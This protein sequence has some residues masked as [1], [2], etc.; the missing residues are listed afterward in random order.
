[1]EQDYEPKPVYIDDRTLS[2]LLR[3]SDYRSKFIA[4][5]TNIILNT[6]SFTVKV[7]RSYMDNPQLKDVIMENIKEVIKKL[8]DR[9]KIDK[10]LS[11]QEIKKCLNELFTKNGTNYDVNYGILIRNIRRY[12]VIPEEEMLDVIIKNINNIILDSGENFSDSIKEIYSYFDIASDEQ[13]NQIDNALATN[14]DTIQKNI[15]WGFGFK[16]QWFERM[17]QF[18]EEISKIGPQFFI[19]FPINDSMESFSKISNELFE[20]YDIE[21]FSILKFGAYDKDKVKLMEEIIN[22]LFKASGKEPNVEEI[23]KIGNGHFSSAYQVG[24]YVLKEGRNRSYC[25]IPNHR[26]I[27]QPIIRKMFESNKKIWRNE[28]EDYFIEV[29]NIADTE[30]WKD[31]TE[32]QIDGILFEIY[33]DLRDSGIIWFDITEKN[34]AKLLKPNKPN[35]YYLD[36]DGKKKEIR[37]D[38]KATGLKRKNTNR[39]IRGRKLC[40]N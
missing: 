5:F 29:Q 37:P 27:M 25:E 20:R 40:Y 11:I 3:D 9:E 26:R 17:T 28:K 18:K 22:E 39:S 10:I 38:I 2:F 32:E 33:S 14:I 4:E 21:T 23:K 24:N 15:I 30:C 1:M 36:I 16:F 8:E 31:M 35:F 12:N 34:A 6:R 19:N 7:L 13:I